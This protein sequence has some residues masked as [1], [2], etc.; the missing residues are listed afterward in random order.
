MTIFV[1]TKLYAMKKIKSIM[2]I[3]ACLLFAS[4]S[5]SAQTLKE[6]FSAEGRENWKPEFTLRGNVGIYTGGPIFSGGVR[7]D[8]KRTIGLMVGKHEIYID[9][10]PG[11]IQYILTNVFIRRYFHL[12]ERQRFAFYSDL[13][14]GA[15]WVYEVNGKYWKNTE[16]DEEIEMIS[17]SPGDVYPII[18]WQPGIRVRFYKNIHMFLGPTIATNCMGVHI[19]IGF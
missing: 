3:A 18:S 8:N 12:G 1:P 4:S 7:I 17:D 13:S 14:A 19:G 16:N 9:D 15:G 11:D 5:L 6:S 2:A 10:V